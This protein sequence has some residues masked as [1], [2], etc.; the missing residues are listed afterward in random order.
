[1]DELVDHYQNLLKGYGRED[2]F[3]EKTR[4]EGKLIGNL[5]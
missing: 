3:W 5:K 4:L 2:V 1:M